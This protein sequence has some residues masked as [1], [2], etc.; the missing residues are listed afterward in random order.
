[1]RAIQ[2]FLGHADSK[3]TEIYAH[4]APSEHELA[5][6]NDAFAPKEPGAGEGADR[7]RLP[8]PEQ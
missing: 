4:Y 8:G 2:S 7:P 3:T 6:V 5:M 1:M